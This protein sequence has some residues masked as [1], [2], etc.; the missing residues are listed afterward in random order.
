MPFK[1]RKTRK[2]IIITIIYIIIFGKN[3][4]NFIYIIIILFSLYN[5]WFTSSFWFFIIKNIFVIK[6][7]TTVFVSIIAYPGQLCLV[8][9]TTNVWLL[10]LLLSLFKSSLSRIFSKLSFKFNFLVKYYISS[11]LLFNNI[12]CIYTIIIYLWK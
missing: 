7:W 4:I 9:L 10:I 3:I 6:S 8:F 5:T 11:K 1:I 12:R 2:I